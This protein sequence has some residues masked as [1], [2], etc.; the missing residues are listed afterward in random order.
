MTDATSDANCVCGHSRDEHVVPLE[1]WHY[2]NLVKCHCRG[3]DPDNEAPPVLPPTREKWE[4]TTRRAREYRSMIRRLTAK[5]RKQQVAAL[6][7]MLDVR[8]QLADERDVS[9]TAIAEFAMRTEKAESALSAE[10][11]KVDRLREFIE[12][13]HTFFA[14]MDNRKSH[15]I[16]HPDNCP[17]SD[18]A[19]KR[20]LAETAPEEAEQ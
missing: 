6:Y 5:V 1:C 7:K 9:S 16:G 19:F 4:R 8:K 3:Y 2:D 15:E 13:T 18:C 12:N 14:L 11:E 10:R 20:V 17:A